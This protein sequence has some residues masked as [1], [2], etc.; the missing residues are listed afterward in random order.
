MNT[1]PQMP[2]GHLL[3]DMCQYVQ[4]K[5]D[6]RANKLH[7]G[8]HLPHFLLGDQSALFMRHFLFFFSVCLYGVLPVPLNNNI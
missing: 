5:G 1:S 2:T 4:L 8:G 7:G 6:L 3:G